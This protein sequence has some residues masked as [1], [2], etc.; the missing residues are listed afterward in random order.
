MQMN[1]TII[2]FGLAIA[3]SLSAK[4]VVAGEQ[5]D[6]VGRA[7]LATTSYTETSISDADG[8]VVY[9]GTMEGVVFNDD[10]DGFLD[11]AHYEVVFFGDTSTI[12]MGY[13]TFTMIDGSRVIARFEGT[14]A[15]PPVFKGTWTFIHGSGQYEGITGSGRYTVTTVSDI[16]LW[17][18]LEGSYELP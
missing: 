17:D 9:H 1:R 4:S 8:H 13:K 15:V 11:N 14:E 6:W 10:G 5:G 2:L 12:D 7:A 3:L 18:I 16:A